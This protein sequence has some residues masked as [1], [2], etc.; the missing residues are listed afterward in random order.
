M[1][2]WMLSMFQCRYTRLSADRRH[3]V[4]AARFHRETILNLDWTGLKTESDFD[5]LYYVEIV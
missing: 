5:A 4:T 3:L 2:E 1:L